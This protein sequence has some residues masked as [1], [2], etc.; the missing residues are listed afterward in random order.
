MAIAIRYGMNRLRMHVVPTCARIGLS[1]LL[2]LCLGY[3]L[4][5]QSSERFNFS[6]Q[7][8]SVTWATFPIDPKLNDNAPFLTI[9][10][11]GVGEFEWKDVEIRTYARGNWSSWSPVK[12]DPH[13][14][15][16]EI[17]GFSELIFVE[18]DISRVAIRIG[19]LAVSLKGYID[20]YN[21]KRRLESSANTIVIRTD[22]D[23][24]AIMTREQWCPDGSC[25]WGAERIKTTVTHFIVHHS[26]GPNNSLNWDAVVRSI[27]HF[28][29]VTRGWDD[30][31]YNWLISPD[32]IVYEGRGKG[33]LGAHFCA[34]NGGTSGICLMG[35]FEEVSPK[36]EAVS[37]LIRFLTMRA[38]EWGIS[39]SDRVFHAASRLTLP[40]VSG[41]RDGCNTTCPGD[42]L[43]DRMD[44][45]KTKT[46]SAINHCKNIVTPVDS[47]GIDA[48]TLYPTLSSGTFTLRIAKAVF[49]P[50]YVYL[51]DLQG[52]LIWRRRVKRRR[53]TFGIQNLSPG[54]YLVRMQNAEMEQ[55]VKLV[56][57]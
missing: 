53:K 20:I 45:I 1:I 18:N 27:W 52:H 51:Y 6:L 17:A 31:G 19:S 21:P 46:D 16:D 7:R 14:M 5:A 39:L 11:S 41:H 10:L 56:K 23:T 57:Q 30:I 25:T 34:Q 44:E 3:L 49:R 26:A 36:E 43:Y 42:K 55:Y 29:V 40:V 24:P 54:M 38:P 35:S 50:V 33:I 48:F 12:E 47:T 28:H 22:C 8:E 4:N 32:G 13:K 9:A 2:F 37:Q 15:Y